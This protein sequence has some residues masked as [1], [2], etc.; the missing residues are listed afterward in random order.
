[1]SDRVVLP[2]E[3]F[4]IKLSALQKH[5]AECREM[6]RTASAHNRAQLEAMARTW[7]ELAEMRKRE[8]AKQGKIEEDHDL[9][10]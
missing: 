7:D 1:V 10:D 4:L 2:Q 8:L 5:A 6:A 9:G 3:V